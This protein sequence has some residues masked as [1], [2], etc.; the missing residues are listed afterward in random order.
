MT[1]ASDVAIGAALKQKINDN[2]EPL[3]FFSRKLTSAEKNYSVYDRELLAVCKAIRYF[4]YILEARRFVMKT[5]HKPLIHAFS[6]K[7]EKASPRQLRHMD[8]IA[9]FTIEI[10]RLAGNE[11]PVADA[12]LRLNEISMPATCN[13]ED[14]QAAQKG[15]EELQT[16]LTS[17]NPLKL[18][19]VRYEPN[20]NIL[21]WLYTTICARKITKKNIQLGTWSISS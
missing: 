20:I 9:Q 2:W 14:I 11:N 17:N 3:G 18:Q 10:I 12:L 16:I 21:H 19:K 8:Y 15:N 4:S 6:R 7:P 13:F 1:D 5:D